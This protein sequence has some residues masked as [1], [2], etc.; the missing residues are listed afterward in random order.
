MPHNILSLLTLILK[1]SLRIF[2]IF[3]LW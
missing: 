1:L 2:I 3:Y